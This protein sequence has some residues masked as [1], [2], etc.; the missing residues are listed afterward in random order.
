LNKTK[1]RLKIAFSNKKSIEIKMLSVENTI[2]K[3]T[4]FL[5]KMRLILLLI[6]ELQVWGG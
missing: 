6:F 1:W 4:Q 3:T 5:L 2:E